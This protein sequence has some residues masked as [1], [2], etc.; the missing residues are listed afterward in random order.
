MKFTGGCSSGQVRYEAEGDP[1]MKAQC[2]CRECRYI[3]GGGSNFFIAIRISKYTKGEARKF[4][5]EDLDNPATWEFCLNRGTRIITDSPG[6]PTVIVKT[7]SLDDSTQ[8]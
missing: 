3:T 6:F 7:D 5:R 1:V 2:S 8:F 4:T